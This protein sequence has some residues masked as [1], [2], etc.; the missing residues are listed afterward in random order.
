MALTIVTNY[1]AMKNSI[2]QWLRENSGVDMGDTIFVNQVTNRPALPY[3]TIQV[4]ADNIKTGD[5]D[6]RP[7]YDAG[8]PALKYRT[9][10]LREMT[11]QVEIYTKPAEAVS[12]I[13]AADRLNFALMALDHPILV[14][15]FNDAN[16][17]IL[18][19]TPV[20]RLDEQL[21]ERW[22][23]RAVSDLRILYTAETIDDGGFGNWVDTVEIP[24]VENNN[25]TVNI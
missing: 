2:L 7:E 17:S 25:L 8:T 14:Q 22:E 10:G 16:I 1:T 4:I 3:A 20:I 5:D 6:V 9:V 18:G 11:I 19:H 12:D 21:G 13:E 15:Q 24:T 23:R